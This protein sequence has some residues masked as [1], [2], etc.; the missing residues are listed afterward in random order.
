MRE[1]YGSKERRGCMFVGVKIVGRGGIWIDGGSAEG[2][3]TGPGQN[4]AT[5]PAKNQ[6]KGFFIVGFFFKFKISS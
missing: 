1:E 6:D 3:F 2:S 4:I 5:L